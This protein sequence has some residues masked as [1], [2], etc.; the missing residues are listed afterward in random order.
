MITFMIRFDSFTKCSSRSSKLFCKAKYLKT[1]F[2]LECTSLMWLTIAFSPSRLQNG[3]I[4]T[5]QLWDTAVSEKNKQR[6]AA[7]SRPSC[8]LSLL[9]STISTISTMSAMTWVCSWLETGW[10]KQY[11]SSM[12]RVTLTEWDSGRSAN[13]G[14]PVAVRFLLNSEKTIKAVTSWYW[15]DIGHILLISFTFIDY[16]QCKLSLKKSKLW[17]N[18]YGI[19]LK[20]K[21]V[22]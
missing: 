14:E 18:V 1:L 20:Q 7:S 19:C 21:S 8:S 11:D 12:S 17:M 6:A 15:I 16:L 3:W 10:V 9:A 5:K 4:S 2:N 13:S 22:K